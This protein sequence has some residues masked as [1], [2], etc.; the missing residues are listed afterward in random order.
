MPD[1]MNNK[2][3]ILIGMALILSAALLI[4]PRYTLTLPTDADTVGYI[5]AGRQLASGEG[6]S[7]TPHPDPA[8]SPFFS[9]FAFQIRSQDG[10]MLLGFPPGFPLLL[11]AGALVS[12]AGMYFVV[13][14]F[15]I[16]GLL[17]LYL[18]GWRWS[19]Q[20]WTGVWAA[21]LLLTAADYTFF[22][23]DAWSGI[24]AMVLISGGILL[25]GLSREE[26]R[27]FPSRILLSL[28]AALLLIFS[29]FIRYANITF[30]LAIGIAEL[31]T[32]RRRFFQQWR[33]RF[34]FYGF[35][36]A[37]GLGI[38][39]FN[40]LY[41]GGP[42]LTS[43]S[44]E[45][46][47]YTFAPFSFSYALGPS[48]IN[49]YSLIEAG[50]SLWRNFPGLILLAPAGWF[51]LKEKRLLS[52]LAVCFSVGLYAVYAFAPADVNSRFLIPVFPFIVLGIAQGITALGTRLPA[53]WM[54]WAGSA[55]LLLVILWGVPAQLDALQQRN[56]AAANYV[57]VVENAASLTPE[58]AVIMS[59]ALNDSL[60]MY[61]NRTVLNYRRIPQYDPEQ[62][63][64]RY[65][66]YAGCL[67]FL[68]DELLANG[69]PVYFIVD[70]VPSIY[71]TL[72]L[73]ES[74]YS[75]QTIHEQPQIFQLSPATGLPLRG[76]ID[77][78]YP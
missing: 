1:R 6:L 69:R 42:L 34:P 40:A 46:G 14:L 41:Y 8:K 53:A 38:L 21:L 35:L 26:E 2:W 24:P 72:P 28:A 29:L 48:P 12:E 62:E 37:G 4:F 68:V 73:L 50:T 49:G 52:V 20:P 7:Y 44:P 59:Y 66:L 30:L 56:T 32:A 55:A 25:F 78:C 43:Y 22:G 39:L 9:M 61:G 36:L 3:V 54:R 11:G 76:S 19:R 17:L 57:H 23:T 77:E 60:I 13:P 16:A 75:L 47:W 27:P 10:R 71:E 45:N 15:A 58:D 67:T 74:T 31:L 33:R 70:Q 63:K 65:D 18:M 51:W 5:M 64:I